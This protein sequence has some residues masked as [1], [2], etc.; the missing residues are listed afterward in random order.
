M[1]VVARPQAALV[2]H[3]R[4]VEALLP[5]FVFVLGLQAWRATLVVVAA[6]ADAW[7]WVVG[8]GAVFLCVPLVQPAVQYLGPLRVAGGLGLLLAVARIVTAPFGA[9]A[10]PWYGLAGAGLFAAYLSLWP[11]AAPSRRQAG[12]ALALG[13]TLHLCDR[14]GCGTLDVTWQRGW[15]STLQALAWSAPPLVLGWRASRGPAG[16]ARRTPLPLAMPLVVMLTTMAFAHPVRA[17]ARLG[18]SLP[19]TFWVLAVGAVGG[20]ILAGL[21]DQLLKV[22]FT[23]RHRPRPL[24]V[25]YQLWRSAVSLVALLGLLLPGKALAWTLALGPAALLINLGA[26]QRARPIGRARRLG[27]LLPL[28]AWWLAAALCVAG[29]RELWP[30]ALGLILLY[31]FA[32]EALWHQERPDPATE[33]FEWWTLPIHLLLLALV[34]VPAATRRPKVSDEPLT[35]GLLRVALFDASGLE[36]TVG[37]QTWALEDVT[38]RLALVYGARRADALRFD[39]PVYWLGRRYHLVVRRQ[40]AGPLAVLGALPPKQAQAVGARG[41]LGVWLLGPDNALAAGVLAAGDEGK[42]ALGELVRAGREWPRVVLGGWLGPL[43]ASP[44]WRPPAGYTDLLEGKGRGQVLLASEGIAAE[45]V[46]RPAPGVATALVRI[47]P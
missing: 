9:G 25:V 33:T 47:E 14:L 3:V 37:R 28:V 19:Q 4:A 6:R 38:P 12:H 13:F 10:A 11:A 27:G 29:R 18:W 22:A 24:R 7:G 5:A 21:S 42:R 15:A 45:S 40:K 1:S 2:E 32:T 43:P 26:V 39:D 36:P 44:A 34:L 46:E 30:A 35:Q 23:R 16:Q 20:M 31:A 17:A 8:A 41:L